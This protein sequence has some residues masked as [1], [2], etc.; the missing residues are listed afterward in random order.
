MGN[1]VITAGAVRDIDLGRGGSYGTDRDVLNHR[2]WDSRYFTTAITSADLFQQPVGAQW[3]VGV[4]TL[5]E[6][7]LYDSGKMPQSQTFLAKRIGV[8]LCHNGT[9]QIEMLPHEASALTVILQNSVFEIIVRGR[10]FD[11]Q[12]PGCIFL[13]LVSQYQASAV[14]AIAGGTM[15]ASGMVGIEPTPIFLDNLVSFTVKHKV[16]ASTAGMNAALTSCF[17][18]LAGYY[19]SMVVTLEGTLTRG[20]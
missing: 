10:E 4:K 3:R 16:Q 7:N 1:N 18:V 15:F 8:A 13:P 12:C 19:A 5:N 17:A 20:K 6:T 2:I 14:T 9:N 11:F